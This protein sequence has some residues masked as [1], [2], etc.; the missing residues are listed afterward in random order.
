MRRCC[1]LAAPVING[2]CLQAISSLAE[3]AYDAAATQDTEPSTYCLSSSFG[4]MIT[5][6]LKEVYYHPGSQTWIEQ[7]AA[8]V[9][10]AMW[11]VKFSRKHDVESGIIKVLV[12][13]PEQQ[14][15]GNGVAGYSMLFDPKRYWF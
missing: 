15:C 13:F 6:L 11:P 7:H 12:T 2:F 9:S 8:H 1:N 3:A 4:V 14:E 5:K 10:T